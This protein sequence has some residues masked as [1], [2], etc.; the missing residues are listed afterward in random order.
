MN[1]QGT[2]T[3]TEDHEI[4]LNKLTIRGEIIWK[5]YHQV[6]TW[7]PLPVHIRHPQLTI[8]TMPTSMGQCMQKDQR[9]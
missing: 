9:Q 4:Q 6:L 3:D 7:K 8:R 2:D 5:L 1:I